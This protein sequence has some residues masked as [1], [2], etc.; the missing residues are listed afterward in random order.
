[1]LFYWRLKKHYAGKSSCVDDYL[2]RIENSYLAAVARSVRQEAME[3]DILAALL[4]QG[5]P[6]CLIKGNEI[7][8]IIYGDPNC[9]SAADI[10]V[11]IKTT[12]LIAADRILNDK[13]YARE[14]SLPLPFCIGRLHHIPYRNTKNGYL[15]ELH[16]DFGYPL[17]FNLTPDE[18]WNG[19][20]GNDTEGYSLLPENMVLMLFLHHFRHAFRELKILTDILWSFYRY[21]K[22]INWQTFAEKLRKIGL[23][24]SAIIILEQLDSLWHLSEGSLESFKIL[25]EQLASF[26][27]K[28]P[29]FLSRY[30]RMDI[31]KDYKLSGA[32]DMQMAKL[33]IDKK[34]KVFYSFFKV[35]FPRP[36]D[37]RAFY[38]GAGSWMLPV[39]YLRFIFW[40]VTKLTVFTK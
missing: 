35:F 1:M 2:K 23:I 31:E 36:Q 12:D 10:D 13:G 26:N 7:A 24:K 21:D 18:I 22:I 28:P 25:Q 15:L 4:L 20:I 19:V 17:Y 14:N 6:A 29:R 30:F 8:R 5:I 3:K 38:P 39:N 40:R 27:I 11:L 34:S 37:V 9:R 16:W 32:L 33:V